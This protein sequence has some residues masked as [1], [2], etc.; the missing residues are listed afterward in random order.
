MA[1]LLD[2]YWDQTGSANDSREFPISRGVKQG[3]TLSS[4][5]FN[6]VIEA[7]FITWKTKISDHGWN[8]K[9]DAPKLT[10][11]RYADDMLLF[12]RNLNELTE[13]LNF[14]Q[15]E[16]SKIGLEMHG[17]KT[18]ILTNELDNLFS[19]MDVGGMFIQ[20]LPADKSHKYLGRMINLHA[21]NRTKV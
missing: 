16:L 19:M 9:D 20:V 18:K 15:E 4:L 3:D 12:A 10:N 2:M 8:L 7:V 5:L 14:L 1:L 6:A 13:M 11:I 21:A 17:D